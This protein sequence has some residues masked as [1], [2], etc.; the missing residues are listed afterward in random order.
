MLP[1]TKRHHEGRGL[2]RSRNQN[3]RDFDLPCF[4]EDKEKV[5]SR[6]RSSNTDGGYSSI[7]TGLLPMAR[8]YASACQW[9]VQT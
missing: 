3:F 2:A 6:A 8:C 1:P 4:M 9:L 5:S 7:V